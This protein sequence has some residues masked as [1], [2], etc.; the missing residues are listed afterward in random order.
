[1]STIATTQAG[2]QRQDIQRL[3]AGTLPV[4]DQQGI[5][6]R[7]FLLGLWQGVI[8]SLV[9]L[10]DP[11]DVAALLLDR[12]LAVQGHG[13]NA[14][15]PPLALSD[16][17]RVRRLSEAS[18][19]AR[20]ILDALEP[21]IS[22][23][24]EAREERFPEDLLDTA[25][26]ILVEA[27]GP[28]HVRTALRDQIRALTEGEVAPVLPSEPATLNHVAR[29]SRAPDPVTE[30]IHEPASQQVV[31]P[32]AAVPEAPQRRR[33]AP[34]RRIDVHV[35]SDV[36]ENGHAVYAVA[37]LLV[38]IDGRR[39]TR[40]IS[41]IVPDATGRL[42]PLVA[43]IDLLSTLDCPGEG[44]TVRIS[45]PSKALV[46]GA[47]DPGSRSRGDASRW[48]AVERHCEG[49]RVEWVVAK[50]GI[51]T[52]LAERCDRLVRQRSEQYSRENAA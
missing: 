17:A 22:S 20:I 6:K 8:G 9:E 12:A 35:D 31:A 30:A 43:T 4:L 36:V 2:A 10:G 50:M 39:E 3:V 37:C 11:E 47:L 21:H 44:E 13:R 42:A 1:M 25:L 19:A 16:E 34:S 24:D 41:G 23:L 52:D 33:G 46:G 26:D 7:S 18:Q 40:E 29:A 48:D 28:S 38:D 32:E 27:W 14:D 49:R 45:S 15:S 51:G 5:A